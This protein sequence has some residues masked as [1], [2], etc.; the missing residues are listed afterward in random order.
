MYCRAYCA[1]YR[2]RRGLTWEV[3]PCAGCLVS[4]RASPGQF[5]GGHFGEPLDFHPR[6]LRPAEHPADT[7]TDRARRPVALLCGA[8]AHRA[9]PPTEVLAVAVAAAVLL[10]ANDRVVLGDELAGGLAVQDAVEAGG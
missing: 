2:A 8:E 10:V 6:L 1:I 9:M 3:R 7:T 5:F 4:L